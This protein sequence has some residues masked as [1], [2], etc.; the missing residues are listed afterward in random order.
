F[1]RFLIMP[2]VWSVASLAMLFFV[3]DEQM[4]YLLAVFCAL[5]LYLLLRQY[6][7]YFYF[8]NKYQAYSLESLTFYITIFSLFF[9]ASASSAGVSLVQ[10]RWYILAPAL[11][12]IFC[13][14]LYQFFWMNKI[15]FV[16]S[17][18]FI[19]PIALI[20]LEFLLA[21]SYLPVGYFVSGFVVSAVGY[22]MLSLTKAQT[23]GSLS[24]KNIFWTLSV[25]GVFLFLVLATAK[26]S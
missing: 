2:F 4:F 19:F 26:W 6:Y 13:L 25:A 9:L 8:P 16:K 5:L 24:R 23:Q 22:V 17:K 10:L 15:D 21:M 3:I 7:I 11:A 1:W 12:F 14:T 20:L 18:I